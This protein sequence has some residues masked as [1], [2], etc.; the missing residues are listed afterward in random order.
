MSDGLNEPQQQA[1]HAGGG[2]M[3]VLAGAG[4]G[5]TRVVT[6]RIAELMRRGTA[7]ERILA[8]TFTNKAAR[9]MQQRVAEL[10][11]KSRGRF[12]KDAA[13]PEIST[14]HSLCVRILRRQIARLG[15]PTNFTIYDRGDQEAAA[16]AALRAINVPDATLRP[17]D[18]LSIISAWKS[19]SVRP[20]DAAMRCTTDKEHLASMAYRRYQN[21][22]R[23]AGAVDFDDLLLLTE[24]LLTGHEDVR[25]AEAG[26]FDHVLVDEY[27]DTNGPQYRIVRALA[28]D[29]RNLCVVGDDDQSIYGWRGAEVRHILRFGADWP[30]ATVVRL[31]NNYRCTGEILT[32]AN[33]LIAFN[34][35]RHAKQ[36]VSARHAGEKPRVVQYKDDGLE[37]TGVVEEIAATLEKD[38]TLQPRDFAILFRTNQQP[39]PFEET[40]RRAKL[41]YVLVGGMSFFDR[42]EVRDALAFLKVLANPED[43]PSLRRIINTPPRGIGQASVKSLLNVAVERGEPLWRTLQQAELVSDLGPQTN[44]AVANFVELIRRHVARFQK[45]ALAHRLQELLG[46]IRYLDDLRR[47]YNDPDEFEARKQSIEQV[48]NSLSDY[49]RNKR[50]ATLRGFLDDVALADGFDSADKDKQL[51]R[52]AVALMTLHA[53]KGLEF[54]RVYLVGLE[55]G[56]LPHHRSLGDDEAN[57]AE[58]RRL[59]YVGMT[60]AQDQLTLTLPLAR[61]KWG[62]AASHDSQPLSLRNHRAGRSSQRPPRP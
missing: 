13:K 23:A 52:N 29:H 10:L 40:L 38:Q 24:E 30:G 25:S 4:A 61:L 59:C 27:Q 49:E 55:E 8:V 60:R 42:R 44:A 56:V 28:G 9:E 5:K 7:P 62:Q 22:V 31:V 15:L 17:G 58:E 48:V 41:P 35:D 43:E 47:Q 14:F 57:I 45:G 53:A 37:A 21:A 46:E 26:R 51:D 54:P 2:P 34:K 11:R 1:V 3:L 19:Q 39:R 12:D 50:G 32:A 33:R 6:F 18:L 36:L 16:R 20:A